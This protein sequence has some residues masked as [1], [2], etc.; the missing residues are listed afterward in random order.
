MYKTEPMTPNSAPSL[1][2]RILPSCPSFVSNIVYP[3]APPAVGGGTKSLRMDS[4]DFFSIVLN[5]TD[6][7]CRLQGIL[8][9]DTWTD[10]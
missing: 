8:I 10:P 4:Y 1:D 9:R 3:A 7:T 2:D 6:E 5:V